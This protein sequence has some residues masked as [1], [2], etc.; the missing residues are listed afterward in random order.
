MAAMTCDCCEM[1]SINGVA[2]HE[3]GCPNIGARWD[4][5]A[6]L[7]IPKMRECFECGCTVD[8]DAPC[9]SDVESRRLLDE[10][11]IDAYRI[12]EGT[13]D[14]RLRT[15]FDLPRNLSGE[16]PSGGF[17]VGGM[18]C[19]A[20]VPRTGRS[21]VCWRFE[22]GDPPVIGAGGGCFSPSPT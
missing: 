20:R 5:D 2:C 13:E 3:H 11:G 10:D 21:G 17:A 8:A 15:C 16:P 1:V 7:W 14:E 22:R 12:Y 9:C 18:R 19:V 4:A 6:E